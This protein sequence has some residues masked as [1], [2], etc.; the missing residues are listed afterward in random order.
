MKRQWRW[1][2][3]CESRSTVRIYSGKRQLIGCELIR[4]RD[5][6]EE[7]EELLR[8]LQRRF[9]S[10]RS[11]L[12]RR[13]IFFFGE[14]NFHCTFHRHDAS[15][16]GCSQINKFRSTGSDRCLARGGQRRRCCCPLDENSSGITRPSAVEFERHEAGNWRDSIDDPAHGNSNTDLQTF[17]VSPSVVLRRWSI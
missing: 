6:N 10:A 16:R 17:Y 1:Y 15:S 9:N 11:Q 3:V 2:W 4:R 14:G 12:L 7:L 5:G 13:P 8:F